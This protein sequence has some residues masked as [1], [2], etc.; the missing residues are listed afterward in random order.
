M[1]DRQAERQRLL[2]AAAQARHTRQLQALTLSGAAGLGKRRSL[3]AFKAA[4]LIDM[5]IDPSSARS[6]NRLLT[7][8]AKSEAHASAAATAPTDRASQGVHPRRPA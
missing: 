4:L 6:G 1:A 3:H 2:Q 8:R 5:S 7:A